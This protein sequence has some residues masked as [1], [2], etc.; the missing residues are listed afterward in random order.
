MT[1]FS[2]VAQLLLLV[3]LS[4]HAGLRFFTVYGPL[5]RP[6]MAVMSFTKKLLAGEPVDILCFPVQP[7][8]RPAGVAGQ[9]SAQQTAPQQA[10]QLQEQTQQQ[11]RPQTQKNKRRSIQDPQLEG[12]EAG[13]IALHGRRTEIMQVRARSHP[14]GQPAAAYSVPTP[15]DDC[16]PTFRDFT[17]VSDVVHGILAACNRTAASLAVGDSSSVPNVTDGGPAKGRHR[18]YN[19]GLGQPHSTLALLQRL[20]QLL[21]VYDSRVRFVR[22][23]AGTPDVWATWADTTAAQRELGFRAAVRLSEGLQEFGDWYVSDAAAVQHL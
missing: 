21:G 2:H 3:L 12:D 4:L 20:Q 8:L 1:Q 22:A 16:I 23:A 6:D 13:L 14:Q 17:A 19:I 10:Q 7:M 9:A 18:I 5:G 15:P 11:Q